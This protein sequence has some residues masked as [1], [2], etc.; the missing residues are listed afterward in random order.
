MSI[1]GFM[2]SPLFSSSVYSGKMSIDEITIFESDLE[3]NNIDKIE[4]VEFKF[5]IYDSSTYDTI[6]ETDVI[7]FSVQ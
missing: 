2:V 7:S 5:Q 1:N 3:D 6:L 4:D